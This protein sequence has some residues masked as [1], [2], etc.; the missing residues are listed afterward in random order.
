MSTHERSTLDRIGRLAR[1]EFSSGLMS[2]TKWRKF[3]GV[4]ARHR[5]T[6]ELMLE[7]KFIDETQLRRMPAPPEAAFWCPR[8]YLDTT[9]LGPIE[10]R[11]IEW[12]SI[13]HRWE[14]PRG[15]GIAPRLV[16][17]QLDAVL[18]LLAR[19]G[20]F[21]IRETDDGLRIDGYAR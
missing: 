14:L 9:T 11:A 5:E 3:F 18:R 7:I 15:T 2:D 17:Q 13:P 19:I 16:S 21:P 10:L 4:L 6:A 12:V 20:K 8:P 1:R